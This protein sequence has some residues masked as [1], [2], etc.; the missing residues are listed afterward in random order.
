MALP[1]KNRLV[2]KAD[3]DRVFKE[4]KT[5]KGSFLFIKLLKNEIGPRV[6]IVIAKR[7][8]PMAVKRNN[9][10]RVISDIVYSLLNKKTFNYDMVVVITRKN[11][12][13]D[14][15]SEVVKLLNK[16]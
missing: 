4:G 8:Y 7:I 1:K 15:M 16:I 9:L 11:N 5:V 10:K 6:G 14:M 2:K 13:K 12:N 3:F